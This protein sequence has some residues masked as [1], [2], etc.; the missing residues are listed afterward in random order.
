MVKFTI[1]G[2]HF[3]KNI[4][5]NNNQIGYKMVYRISGA[6]FVR[7]LLEGQRD[8]Q[9]MGLLERNFDLSSHKL[10]A[11]LQE[12]FDSTDSRYRSLCL[13]DAEM[14][15]LVA[16]KL[17]VCLVA[18]GIKLTK[19]DLEEA[20][21]GGSY[22]QNAVLKEVNFRNADL[23]RCR[24]PRANF[25][26]SKLE[27]AN[28]VEAFCS[29]AYFQGSVLESAKCKRAVFYGAVFKETSLAN[30]DFTE[31]GLRG[32]K[33]PGT[34][35]SGMKFTGA[36]LRQADLRGVKNLEKSSGLEDVNFSG[37]IVS[38][39]EKAIIEEALKRKVPFIVY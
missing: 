1:P 27:R 36:D 10:Y 20:T 23:Y 39:A 13:S 7:R 34:D 28:L 31:A 2:N 25:T 4:S 33:F 37:T 19:V 6:E 11:Q 29:E 22:F 32:A 26:D 14:E 3:W 9:E 12:S 38:P 21:L 16:K 18:N 5:I 24:A 17:Y 35:V 30:A 15:G 8:F